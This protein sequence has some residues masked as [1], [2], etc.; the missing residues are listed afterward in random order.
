MTNPLVELFNLD[1]EPAQFEFQPDQ[2]I[3]IAYRYSDPAFDAKP[4][5]YTTFHLAQYRPGVFQTSCGMTVFLSHRSSVPDYASRTEPPFVCCA[6]CSNRAPK[7][8]AKHF[9]GRRFKFSR[10]QRRTER[11]SKVSDEYFTRSSTPDDVPF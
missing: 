7:F 5:E 4:S 3:F 10:N 1:R 2:L 8:F 11:L 6:V 9:G